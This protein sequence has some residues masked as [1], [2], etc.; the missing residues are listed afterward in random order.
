MIEGVVGQTLLLDLMLTDGDFSKYPR[1]AIFDAV[2]F[3]VTIIDLVHV[4]AGLYQ[5]SWVPT[6]AGHY[7]IRYVIYADPAHTTVDV[8]YE[9]SA[10]HVLIRALDQDT[11]FQKVLGHLG[12]NVRDDVLTYDSNS[13][14]LTFRRR[15][16]PTRAAANAS[17]PGGTGEGEIF[18]ILGSSAH[19]DAA[20]WETLLRTLEP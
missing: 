12:E 11:A 17:T 13:R 9:R 20:R 18:T 19:F 15:I 6:T 4:S 3:L 10:D 14:P 8:S 2:G 5:I 1:A 16:F 7:S